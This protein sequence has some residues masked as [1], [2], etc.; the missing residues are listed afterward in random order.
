[1]E[2]KRSQFQETKESLKKTLAALEVEREDIVRGSSQLIDNLDKAGK[3]IRRQVLIFCAVGISLAISYFIVLHKPAT[4]DQ[5][6]K[7]LVNQKIGA[8]PEKDAS[9]ESSKVEEDL[10]KLLAQ[11]RE[12]QLNK[13]INL[14][15]E[16][17]SP[18]F[19]ELDRKRKEILTSW[20]K[21]TYI[22]SQFT[23][24]DLQKAD[25]LTILGNVIWSIK[26]K[27]QNIG[28]IRNIEKSYSVTFSKRSGRWLIDKIE[29][30]DSS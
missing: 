10:I 23:L 25:H 9:S 20:E 2:N 29:K 14:L 16:A 30:R 27:N 26:A 5:L 13:N 18:S 19:P 4:T 15:L 12:G 7:L 3:K 24:T 21:Y 17:Y 22:D 6:H 1:M 11:I 28:T 8:K